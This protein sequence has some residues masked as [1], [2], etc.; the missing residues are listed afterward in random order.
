MR[1]ILNAW[2]VRNKKKEYRIIVRYS[3]CVIRNFAFLLHKT[4]R[5]DRFSR[6]F[7]NPVIKYYRKMAI[8]GKNT[9]I[10][11]VNML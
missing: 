2:N 4:L 8:N 1:N 9:C 10:M 5:R 7:K 11:S 6:D 3:F